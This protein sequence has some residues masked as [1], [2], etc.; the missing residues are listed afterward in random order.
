MSNN[1]C[2][3]LTR[4][5]NE[6]DQMGEYFVAVFQGKP[7][8]Q[9]VE[10]PV[11]EWARDDSDSPKLGHIVGNLLRKGGG[12]IKDEYTWFFLKE[13]AFQDEDDEL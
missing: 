11:A 13:I 12:R 5:H 8:F 1:T 3:V 7:T 2:W 10:P 9:Q 4:E 6:Y